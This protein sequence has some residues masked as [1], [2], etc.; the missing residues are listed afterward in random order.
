[1]LWVGAWCSVNSG[2]LRRLSKF[3]ISPFFL[4]RPSLY[5]TLKNNG[6]KAFLAILGASFSGK[7]SPKNFLTFGVDMSLIN[8]ILRIP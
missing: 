3:K 4:H 7:A 2:D 5:R 8:I 1:M 6:K